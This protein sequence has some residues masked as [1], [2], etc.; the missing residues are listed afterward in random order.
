MEIYLSLEEIN[1]I[2]QTQDTYKNLQTKE[3]KKKAKKVYKKSKKHLKE[4]KRFIQAI[5]AKI[6]Y[7]V[8][9]FIDDKISFS[10]DDQ[11]QDIAELLITGLLKEVI[12]VSEDGLVEG[13]FD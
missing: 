5:S 7:E 1:E 9:D 4:I 11:R 8:Y 6:N 12:E 2:K 3:S 13:Y 10:D